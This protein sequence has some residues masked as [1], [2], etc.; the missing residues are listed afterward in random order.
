MYLSGG[1]VAGRQCQK[2]HLLTAIWRSVGPPWCLWSL[3][4]VRVAGGG[5]VAGAKESSL[6]EEMGVGCRPAWSLGASSGCGSPG[7]EIIVVDRH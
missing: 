4:A 6:P 5:G 2:I 3:A 1:V 7:D